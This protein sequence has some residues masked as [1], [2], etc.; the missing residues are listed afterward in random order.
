M[1][2]VLVILSFAVFLSSC[3]PEPKPA[4]TQP[5]RKAEGIKILDEYRR[6][7][8]SNLVDTQVVQT[9][10]LG[11]PFMPGGTLAR[12]KKGSREYEMFLGQL[13]RSDQAAFLLLDWQ[14]ALTGRHLLPSFGGYFGEDRGRPV[15]VFSKGKWIAGIV[16]L[17]EKEADAQARLLAAQIQ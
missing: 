11:K 3:G 12:Y 16:G 5:P 15:F 8:K 7:P 14:K 17:P 1:R 10:L 6:F 9:E 4:V 2:P 13:P